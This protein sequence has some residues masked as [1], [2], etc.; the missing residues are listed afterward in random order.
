MNKRS[1]YPWRRRG[2]VLKTGER[3]R[4]SNTL[5]SRAFGS[6]EV[7]R[8]IRIIAV[9]ESCSLFRPPPDPLHLSYESA[10]HFYRSRRAEGHVNDRDDETRSFAHYH[11]AAKGRTFVVLGRMKWR[12][13]WRR[14][15]RE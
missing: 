8:V 11:S 10:S 4:V 6:V 3:L 14:R 2:F 5:K 7:I 1:S 12:E 13:E 9:P 15:M